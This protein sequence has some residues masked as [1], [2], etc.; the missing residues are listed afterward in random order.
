MDM[1]AFNSVTH[2]RKPFKVEAVEVTRENIHE[3]SE[4]IGELKHKQDGTPYIQSDKK[5]VGN[6]FKVWPGFYV[7]LLNKKVR[8]YSRRVFFEQFLELDE[9]TESWVNYINGDEE[10]NVETEKDPE[11]T[12]NLDAGIADVEAGRVEE[13]DLEK[14]EGLLADTEEDDSVEPLPI[15]DSV[16]PQEGEI[17]DHVAPAQAADA[18][19]DDAPAETVIPVVY[20]SDQD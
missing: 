17:N 13:L 11:E 16:L 3:L 2:I 20:D 15:P 14:V 10:K 6:T 5:L 8:C 19:L 7:T 9:A 4:F 1:E 12:P 18:G